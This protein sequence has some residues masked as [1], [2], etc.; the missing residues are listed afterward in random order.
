MNVLGTTELVHL[1]TTNMANI[2]LCIFHP[3]FLKMKNKA[4]KDEKEERQNK[5]MCVLHER[6]R[7]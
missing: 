7:E 4:I 6:E 5:S 2:M 3:N 1:N